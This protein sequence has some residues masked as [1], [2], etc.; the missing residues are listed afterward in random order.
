MTATTGEGGVPTDELEKERQRRGNEGGG[1]G[2]VKELQAL[3]LLFECFQAMAGVVV[4]LS[5]GMERRGCDSDEEECGQQWT[6][7]GHR[8]G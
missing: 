7:M 5:G 6:S 4:A 3:W 2:S 1:G 8:R